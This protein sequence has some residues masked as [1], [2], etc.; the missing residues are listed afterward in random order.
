M[1][2]S[3]QSS[4]DYNLLQSIYYQDRIGNKEGFIKIYPN[5]SHEHERVKFEIALKLKKEGWKVYSECRFKNNQGRADLVAIRNGMGCIIE[6]MTSEKD[7]GHKRFKY[8][9]EFNLI[10]VNTKNFKIEEFKI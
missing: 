1:T 3:I 7:L 9:H 2:S 8:P 6:V 10:E 5:N 4:L